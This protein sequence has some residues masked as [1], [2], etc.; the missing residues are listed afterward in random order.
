M[1]SSY[2][3]DNFDSEGCSKPRRILS[4][5]QTCCCTK[6]AGW[7]EPCDLCPAEQTSK[8]RGERGRGKGGGVRE[9]KG[10]VRAGMGRSKRGLREGKRGVREG[11]GGVRE[12]DGGVRGRLRRKNAELRRT[13][14]K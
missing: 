8:W 11:K 9:E 4:N 2:C 6:G 10:A 13:H 14:S 12:G 3:F 5:K 1:R 7:G